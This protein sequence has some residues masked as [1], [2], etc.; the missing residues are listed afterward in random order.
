LIFFL[1]SNISLSLSKSASKII[2]ST[3][4]KFFIFNKILLKFSLEILSLNL[5]KIF[6]LLFLDKFTKGFIF[7]VNDFSIPINPCSNSF[8]ND[9]FALKVLK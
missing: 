8:S 5:M 6:G 7:L 1:L 3:N 9:A 2:A 4:S